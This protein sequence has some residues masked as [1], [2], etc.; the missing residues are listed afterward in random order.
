MESFEGFLLKIE[1]FKAL[2]YDKNSQLFYIRE[3][4]QDLKEETKNIRI[5]VRLSRQENIV[6]E[7]ITFEKDK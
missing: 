3:K 6:F 2:G 1:K 5:R 4:K 7:I